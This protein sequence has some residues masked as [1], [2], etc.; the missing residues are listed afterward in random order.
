[1]DS[2][3]IEEFSEYLD[4]K[5]IV[6]DTSDEVLIAPMLLSLCG[7]FQRFPGYICEQYRCT[8]PRKCFWRL[9]SAKA[10][11]LIEDLVR[12]RASQRVVSSIGPCVVW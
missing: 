7:N 1:M 6:V 11:Q 2:S 5:G 4:E 3:S 12:R 9:Y 8:E 10:L